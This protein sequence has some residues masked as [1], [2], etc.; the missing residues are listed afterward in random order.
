MLR[1]PVT[2]ASFLMLLS[3]S[4]QAKPKKMTLPEAI[5]FV[6]PSVVQISARGDQFRGAIGPVRLPTMPI[7]VNLGSG[8]LVSADGY[9][10]TARHV[11]EAFQ[12]L[13]IEGQKTLMVGLALPNLENYKSGAATLSIRGSFR[14]TESEVVDED[15]RPDLALLKLKVNPFTDKLGLPPQSGNVDQYVG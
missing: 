13:Q 3:L 2:V 11:V 9:A 15:V 8:F 6:R 14:L 12:S 7:I 10:V 4:V 1:I 5:D